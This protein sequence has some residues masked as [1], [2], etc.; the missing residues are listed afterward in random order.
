MLNRKGQLGPQGLE[1]LPMV[2]MAF[3]VA[4]AAIIILLNI[5]SGHTGF[6]RQD[7][8]HSA[9]KRL[10]ET[11]SGEVFKSE[12]SR[13]YGAV[14]DWALVERAHETDFTLQN[15]VG[16]VEYGFWAEMD[17]GSRRLE[18]GEKPPD[19]ALAY[20]APFSALADGVLL[21]GRITVKTWKK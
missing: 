5:S 19:A 21:N 6:S 7:D 4:I 13:S 15:I 18:F 10:A 3:I 16:S 20:S 14:L 17:I 8:L 12:E 9:G 2:V 11:L 1:D